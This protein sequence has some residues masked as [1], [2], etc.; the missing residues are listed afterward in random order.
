MLMLDA[1]G[2]SKESKKSKEPENSKP[3]NPTEPENSKPENP[4]EADN[5][6]PENP[7]E[8][9]NSKPENPTEADN[10]KPENPTEAENSK[11]P[12]KTK[13][14]EEICRDWGRDQ[15]KGKT[16]LLAGIPETLTADDLAALN[17]L[18][19]LLDLRQSLPEK[20]QQDM[21]TAKP[22][23][24]DVF[25]KAIDEEW[26]LENL[27]YLGI[28]GMWKNYA[29]LLLSQRNFEQL[30]MLVLFPP[31]SFRLNMKPV[32]I[33]T[34][35]KQ[36]LYMTDLIELNAR[37]QVN[38]LDQHFRRTC[39]C[40]GHSSCNWYSY[41]AH[42]TM[43]CYVAESSDTKN[44]TWTVDLCQE[45]SCKCAGLGM[46]A[47]DEDENPIYYGYKCGKWR[48]GDTLS[49]CWAGMDTSCFNRDRP[50]P[51]DYKT[52]NWPKGMLYMFRSVEPCSNNNLGQGPGGR[53]QP[54]L[55]LCEYLQ[56]SLEIFML[57]DLWP[58]WRF[59]RC[60]QG[61]F[62]MGGIIFKFICNR[63][64][65]AIQ[66]EHQFQAYDTSED[67]DDAPA[68]AGVAAGSAAAGGAAAPARDS[69]TAWEGAGH[70][71][72]TA[73]RFNREDSPPS[74]FPGV[75]VLPGGALGATNGLVLHPQKWSE[76][77]V[78]EWWE[79]QTKRR[80][81]V[82]PLSKGTDGRNIMRWNVSRF[83]Q[84]LGD[85]SQRQPEFLMA[86]FLHTHSNI[87][88]AVRVEDLRNE[89]QRFEH[90]RKTGVVL[91]ATPIVNG[92]RRSSEKNGLT[93]NPKKRVDSKQFNSQ[94]LAP[95]RPTTAASHRVPTAPSLPGTVPSN[96]SPMGP[97]GARA[98]TAS[99]PNSKGISSSTP[100]PTVAVA[101][102]GKVNGT[103]GT[104]GTKV[105]EAKEVRRRSLVMED[106]G[107]AMLHQLSTSKAK[108]KPEEVLMDGKPPRAAADDTAVVARRPKSARVEKVKDDD[109]E[110]TRQMFDKR[111]LRKRHKELFAQ[112]VTQW[113]RRQID[114]PSPEAESCRVRVYVRKRPLFDYEKEAETWAFGESVSDD[115]V[116]QQCAA[117]AVQHMLQGKVA[118]LF[119]FGQTGSGKTHTMSGLCQRAAQHIF[120]S[121]SMVT[122]TA[123]EIAG[124]VMRDLLDHSSKELK[125][126]EETWT[127]KSGKTQILG[128]QG[129]DASSPEALLSGLKEAQ[130]GRATRATQ[131]NEKL[132]GITGD[133]M[134]TLVDCAGSER[135][136]DSTQHDARSRKDAAEINST[137]FALKECFR[138]MRSSKGQPPYRESL[139]TRVL[140]DSFGSDEAMVVA[141]GTVSPSAKDT[142]HSIG[143]WDIHG[144]NDGNGGEDVGK[145]KQEVET[146]WR[147]VLWKGEKPKEVHPKAWSEA[148][149]R[150]WVEEAAAGRA[151][152]FA[153]AVSKGTDGKILG[154][155]G[156][157][158]GGPTNVSCS[159]VAG[160]KT[161]ATSS[162]RTYA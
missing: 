20:V 157:C 46:P 110:E 72:P 136:E 130:A 70:V 42:M 161:W 96:G 158:F 28:L 3:E 122:L 44:K 79:K 148:E 120:Q 107:D 151:K 55:Q 12:E 48:K 78:R 62:P 133:A 99:R 45:G 94:E 7:T 74:D 104:N 111:E 149:V 37:E 56:V 21:P 43:W 86:S 24:G 115:E 114:S 146:W 162:T 139:L 112:H 19:V 159:S 68:A 30:K 147:D 35:E 13:E 91:K 156:I 144:F 127:D 142:E 131:V 16:N 132:D 26:T 154:E 53:L 106:L 76:D 102:K 39:R 57:Q 108:Q 150:Q 82:E 10:S 22:W 51:P 90:F 2:E 98:K 69:F 143:T 137:I 63:C 109:P 145:P 11:E 15:K 87:L 126:R 34:E 47:E 80:P 75:P 123:F 5:S 8:A 81:Q 100:K 67:S 105:K 153:A 116:Y 49:W 77:Q 59:L 71:L 17:D 23:A 92:E 103:N 31:R 73:Q 135:R 9:E 58:S 125:I 118:T 38:A 41:G 121:E 140:S 64:G 50:L 32:T 152:Q 95:K 101:E 160:M 14:S 65:D 117:D 33:R 128:L 89:V 27:E 93:F 85:R 138:V 97:L 52:S 61:M 84:T 54:A 88:R 83:E 4:T 155:Q 40:E 1:P 124:K 129:S 18:P 36:A 25:L 66:T 6:K 134:L 60:L 29:E 119:M 141:I 113:R